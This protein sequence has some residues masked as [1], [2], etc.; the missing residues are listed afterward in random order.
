MK[1]AYYF[2][3]IV[4]VFIVGCAYS[5]KPTHQVSDAES[6]LKD[7]DRALSSGDLD[8]AMSFFTDDCVYE[9]IALGTVKHGKEEVKA[10]LKIVLNAFPDYRLEIVSSIISGD[11]AAIEWVMTGTHTGPIFNVQ[12]T[13]KSILIRGTSITEL[14]DGKI[15]R[16]SDYYNLMTLLQQLGVTRAL[17]PE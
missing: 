11:L 13:G 8:K 1:N 16:N 2:L 7:Y 10:F 3:A 4:V 6:L 17:P 14:Q 9:D 12:V 15:R 5:N